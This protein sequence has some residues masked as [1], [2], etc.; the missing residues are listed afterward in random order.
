MEKNIPDDFEMFKVFAELYPIEA[1]D[2]RPDDFCKFIRSKGYNM[3]DAQ[4][5]K[6]VDSCR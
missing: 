4:I 6:F 1:Y 5:K 3:T 2:L